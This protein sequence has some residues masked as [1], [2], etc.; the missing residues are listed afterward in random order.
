MNSSHHLSVSDIANVLFFV[1]VETP[2]VWR[3]VESRDYSTS[4][5]F[6]QTVFTLFQTTEVNTTH[7]IITI[8]ER[9]Q[10]VFEAA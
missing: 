2:L 4:F 8:I 6:N 1:Y 3:F 5:S 9:K 7:D 10:T